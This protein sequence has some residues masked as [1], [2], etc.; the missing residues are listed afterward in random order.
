MACGTVPDTYT[1]M[2]DLHDQ[3]KVGPLQRRS[4]KFPSQLHSDIINLFPTPQQLPN[5]PNSSLR[6]TATMPKKRKLAAKHAAQNTRSRFAS[7][8][9]TK[10][11]PPPA[12]T[13]TKPGPPKKQHKPQIIPPTIPFS[14]HER[15]LLLGEGDLSFAVSLVKHHNCT[16]VV[17][18]VFE[19]SEAELLEKYPHAAENIEA[20]KAPIEDDSQSEAEGENWEED[21]GSDWSEDE[22][23]EK[24]SR[25]VNRSKIVYGIDATK[26]FPGSTS[27][28]PPERIIFNFPHVGGQSTDVN[29]QVRANQ[30]LLV[31]FFKHALGT[32]STWVK[33]SSSNTKSSSPSITVTLFESEPYTLW[34]IRDL[35]R[36]S[37]LQVERSFKF[38]W[39]VYPGYKH[40]RTCGVIKGKDGK[41]AGWK[42]EDR[43]ARSYIFVRKDEE[44]GGVGSEAN[45]GNVG[46]GKRKRKGDGDGEEDDSE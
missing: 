14:P 44:A 29:R 31:S 27:K 26:G 28:P 24:R 41:E 46:S 13:T 38:D 8:P 39:G 36:H 42:G 21:Y 1:L 45:A 10:P 22:G 5:H 25:K 37:G 40:A 2:C 11:Q 23:K 19:K 43:G 20:I 32:L 16:D 6:K 15:I 7:K 9:S 17:A 34:N 33:R 4:K 18:T 3:D 30:S 12:S 35:A